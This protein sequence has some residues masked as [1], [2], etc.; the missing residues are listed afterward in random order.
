[1]K[2]F[3]VIIVART[4]RIARLEVH[5]GTGRQVGIEVQ[6]PLPLQKLAPKNGNLATQRTNRS[7]PY[8]G[9]RSALCAKFQDLAILKPI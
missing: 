4:V 1:M 2:H 9:H 7:D 3:K 8:Q 6:T 5:Q